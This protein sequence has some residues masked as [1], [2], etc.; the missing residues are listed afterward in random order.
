MNKKRKPKWAKSFKDHIGFIQYDYDM[1]KENWTAKLM[2]NGSGCQ[3]NLGRTIL[4]ILR[5]LL[6]AH[7]DTL[8]GC[9]VEYVN[10]AGGDVDHGC[11]IWADEIRQVARMCDE[12]T[13]DVSLR[14]VRMGKIEI[15]VVQEREK[16]LG[17]ICDWLRDNLDTLWQ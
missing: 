17:K 1:K 12:C 3:Q 8:T 5:D 11:E 13:E 10:E 16:T 7:A 15:E 14:S 6:K 9:P 4:I 2:G